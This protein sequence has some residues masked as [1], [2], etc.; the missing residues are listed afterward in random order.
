M[1]KWWMFGSGEAQVEVAMGCF[2]LY[3]WVA[4]SC[5]AKESRFCSKQKAAALGESVESTS[6][7]CDADA[8]RRKEKHGTKSEDVDV[9]QERATEDDQAVALARVSVEEL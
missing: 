5:R 2:V 7:S 6:C 1:S 8:H 4:V 9:D 3:A